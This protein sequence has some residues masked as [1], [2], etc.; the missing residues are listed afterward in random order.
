LPFEGEGYR[1]DAGATGIRTELL[2]HYG[3]GP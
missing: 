1:R 3:P 2:D